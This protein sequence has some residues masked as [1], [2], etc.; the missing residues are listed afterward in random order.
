MKTIPLLL[1]AIA[2]SGGVNA[3][4]SNPVLNPRPQLS[5][6]FLIYANHIHSMDSEFFDDGI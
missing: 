2:G 3:A 6:S 1:F 4:V 5:V